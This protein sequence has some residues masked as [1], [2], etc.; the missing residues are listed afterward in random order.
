M[1]ILAYLIAIRRSRNEYLGYSYIRRSYAQNAG[2]RAACENQV[3]LQESPTDSKTFLSVTARKELKQHYKG[4]IDDVTHKWASGSLTDM[5]IV[6]VS[7]TFLSTCRSSNTPGSFTIV[8]GWLFCL[9]MCQR[10]KLK[11]IISKHAA[12]VLGVKLADL[13]ISSGTRNTTADK[14][15]HQRLHRSGNVTIRGRKMTRP[16]RR[17]F[18][19]LRRDTSSDNINSPTSQLHSLNTQSH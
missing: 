11:Q 4:V 9:Y 2:P 1:A 6:A 3:E 17:G 13:P 14:H 7:L 12:T 10:K 16:R 8:G 18:K 19:N 5:A 15:D